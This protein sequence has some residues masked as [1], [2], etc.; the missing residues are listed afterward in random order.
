MTKKIYIAFIAVIVLGVIVESGIR[1]SGLVDFPLYDRDAE[2]GYIPKERQSG[3]FINKNDWYFNDKSMPIARDWDST[4]HPNVF[5]IGNS[6]IMGGNVYQ[7][8]DK[9]S[10]QIQLRI[11][12]LPL[13]WPLAIGGW[14][15]ENEETYLDRHPEITSQVDYIAWEY[16][17]GGLSGATPWSSEYTFPTH[18]PAVATWYVIKR[19]VL[20]RLFH[21]LTQ[22]ELPV[23]GQATPENLARFD[24]EVGKLSQSSKRGFI[25]LYPNRQQLEQARQG[26]EWLP[27]R[28]K[29][30]GIADKHGLRIVDIATMPEWNPSLY[31]D[32]GT[33]PTIE[34]NKILAAILS[35]EIKSDLGRVP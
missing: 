33:H 31:R 29:I 25:W 30:Q 9:L 34:G 6:I 28:Q 23:T 7:Q 27:E 13:I 8:Q 20:P 12:S 24:A 3:A 16:M 10:P 17:S 32:D 18:S 22:S 21:S 35:H 4:I 1:L 2:I 15:Q 19:Y 11:G 5:L 26:L 14:T